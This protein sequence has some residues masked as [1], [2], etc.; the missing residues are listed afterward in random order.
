MKTWDKMIQAALDMYVH[1]DKYTYCLGCQGEKAESKA[2]K[3]KYEYYQ[4]NGY[5][6]Q[7]PLPY[8]EWKKLHK[9]QQCFD[10]SGFINHCAELP[11]STTS[12]TYAE[13]PKNIS[14]ASGVAGSAL[15]TKGHVLL[16]IG[17]GFALEM[18]SYANPEIRMIRIAENTQRITSSHRI[19]GIDYTGATER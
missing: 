2:V 18:P 10:C 16:D 12:W 15:W 17:Y 5:A 11:R 3:D 19:T 1:R 8:A 4:A 6:D 9:G 13:M 14:V 7:M